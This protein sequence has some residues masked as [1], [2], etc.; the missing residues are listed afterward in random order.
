MLIRLLFIF[1]LLGSGRAHAEPLLWR[2]LEQGGQVMVMRHATTEPGIGDPP[3]FRLGDCTTQR[4]LSEAGRREAGEV[5]AEFVRRG[6][7]VENVLSSEWCRCQE[8]AKL[9]FGKVESWQGANSFFDN[10]A[11]RG[12]RTEAMRRRVA[13]YRGPGNLMIVTHQVNIQALAGVSTAMAEIVVLTPDLN[14]GFKVAGKL[15][16]D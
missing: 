16:L 7:V 4:N 1:L 8:T 6:I 15:R 5:G 10:A 13:G 12:M 11:E 3:G 2:L 14:G 9:A